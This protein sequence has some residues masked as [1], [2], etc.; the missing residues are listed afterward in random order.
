MSKNNKKK[1]NNNHNNNHN[2]KNNDIPTSL[3]NPNR[4]DRVRYT[5]F[6]L[7]DKLLFKLEIPRG[8]SPEKRFIFDYKNYLDTQIFI[9][10]RLMILNKEKIELNPVLIESEKKIKEDFRKRSTTF[11][12][13]TFARF[14]NEIDMLS[15]ELRSPEL[16]TYDDNDKLILNGNNWKKYIHD[17]KS[18]FDRI[19]MAPHVVENKDK[20]PCEG[21]KITLI[22]DLNKH[23]NVELTYDEFYA[24]NWTL[25]NTDINTMALNIYLRMY[26]RP[27]KTDNFN[28]R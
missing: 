3:G 14:L 10:I 24:L 17:V 28:R 4:L 23:H 1:N 6:Y 25:K 26:F 11:N 18:S 12:M 27:V 2:H 20:I 9:D 15:I 7:P 16:F 13:I 22:D 8:L 5:I 21:V 19:I